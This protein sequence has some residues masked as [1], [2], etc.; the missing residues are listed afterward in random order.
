MPAESEGFLVVQKLDLCSAGG[1]GGTQFIQS[2]TI[3]KW[4]LIIKKNR[5][6]FQCFQKQAERWSILDD[7]LPTSE[8]KAGLCFASWRYVAW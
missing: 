7:A 6:V 2:R 4:Q 3:Q 1:L 8:V 5:L